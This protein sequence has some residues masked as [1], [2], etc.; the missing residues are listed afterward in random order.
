[1]NDRTYIRRAKDVGT[2][3]YDDCT[4]EGE[5]RFNGWF[6]SQDTLT[7]ADVLSDWIGMLTAAYNEVIGDGFLEDLRTVDPEDPNPEERK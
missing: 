1:M 6:D 4:G 3:E 7:Q 2:L 5:I